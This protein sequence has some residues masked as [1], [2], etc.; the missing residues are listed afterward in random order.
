MNYQH[1]LVE[2][3]VKKVDLN[4]ICLK[5][6]GSEQVRGTSRTVAQNSTLHE[7][8]LA[9]TSVVKLVVQLSTAFSLKWKPRN[10]LSEPLVDERA[11][12]VLYKGEP[13]QSSGRFTE[14]SNAD[15]PVPVYCHSRIYPLLVTQIPA[16]SHP[17]Y[18]WLKYGFGSTH[19][20]QRAQQ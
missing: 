14:V 19:S 20:Q 6:F 8:A 11:L 13:T 3:A 12:T 17:P 18:V 10:S 15:F 5:Y 1:A 4:L 2:T 9:Y 16:R 7:E